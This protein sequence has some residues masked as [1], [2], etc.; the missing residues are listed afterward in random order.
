M[1]SPNLV[2]GFDGADDAGVYRIGADKAIVQALDCI[3][4]VVD[5]PYVFGQIAAANALS[6]V[7]SMGG[8]PICAMNIAA[9]AS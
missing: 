9:T 7:Y 4:P 3:T 1:G 6:D 8:R 5:D 2:L